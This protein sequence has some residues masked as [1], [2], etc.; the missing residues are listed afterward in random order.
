MILLHHPE[1]ELSRTLLASK[2]EGMQAIDWTDQAQ[3]EAYVGPS[4]SAFPSVV[5]EVPAHSADAAQYGP[6][7]EFLGM[8][9]VTI[10]ARQEALRMPASWQAV[11]AYQE[12]VAR[13]A[14]ENPAE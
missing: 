1:A 8:G 3:R 4:P 12:F 10:P 9:R 13:R 6:D 11:E 7:G 2:P 5:V 14:V